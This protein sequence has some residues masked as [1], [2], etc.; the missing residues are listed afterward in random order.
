MY[1][2]KALCNNVQ[3]DV[4]YESQDL[5]T[6]QMPFHGGINCMCSDHGTLLSSENEGNHGTCS[7][8]D[9]TKN[10]CKKYLLQSCQSELVFSRH[11]LNRR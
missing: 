7:N 9:E 8:I 6:A 1:P 10:T 2:E 3:S 11:L 4:I 5:E